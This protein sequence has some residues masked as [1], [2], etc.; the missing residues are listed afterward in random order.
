[1]K[2]ETI[3]KYIEV[4]Q[5]KKVESDI[6]LSN[7]KNWLRREEVTPWLT[8]TL[9]ILNNIFGK[10]NDNTISFIAIITEIKKLSNDTNAHEEIRN[11]FLTLNKLLESIIECLNAGIDFSP[12]RIENNKISIVHSHELST[13]NFD[14]K[15][16]RVNKKVFIVHGH[17]HGFRD[18]I[19]LFVQK[20]GLD[21]IILSDEPNTGKTI[22]EKLEAFQDVSYTI[23]LL[24]PDDLGKSKNENDLKTRARQNVIFEIGL[25]MGWLKRRNV[26][27]I[28]NNVQELPSDL[29]GIGYLN[30]ENNGKWLLFKELQ[31]AGFDVKE[32]NI[33]SQ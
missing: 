12:D 1:M 20:L 29:E 22:I 15:N 5:K 26:C 7:H 25:F 27:T 33:K 21:T 30:F 9:N 28:V 24:T 18:K 14:Q 16:K 4:L 11:Q 8:S 6:L 32:E 23:V 31:S 13:P 17:D 3:R 2:N 19:A 10:E